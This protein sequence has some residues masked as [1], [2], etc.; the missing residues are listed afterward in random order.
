[1]RRFGDRFRSLS[2][3]QLA[4]RAALKEEAAQ[5]AAVEPPVAVLVYGGE[6]HAHG[7]VEARAEG[8]VAGHVHRVGGQVEHPRRPRLRPLQYPPAVE[9]IPDVAKVSQVV[10]AQA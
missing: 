4:P 6:E 7:K 9:Q 5:L 2:A 10:V 8:Q 1:M 3:R